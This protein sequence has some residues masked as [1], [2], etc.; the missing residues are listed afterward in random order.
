MS[1]RQLDNIEDREKISK[2]IAKTSDLIRKKYRT[3]KTGKI[4]ED[5]ALERHFKPIV[6]PLKQIVENIE[7]SQ[8][9]KKKPMLQRIS[10]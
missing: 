10:I 1:I 9:V 7:E 2:Q 3:L 5:I 8:P 4:D 6:E